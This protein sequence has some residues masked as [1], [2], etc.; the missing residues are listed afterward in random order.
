M[1]S[2]LSEKGVCVVS[3]G[4]SD[5]MLKKRP[6]CIPIVETEEHSRI[7]RL[8]YPDGFIDVHVIDCI[9]PAGTRIT[10]HCNFR[11]RVR[12]ED[13]WRR[14]CAAAG[15]AN[16]DLYGNWEF[17]PYDKGSSQRLIAVASG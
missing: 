10:K 13:D 3:Q 14:L 7:F 16:V 5:Q 6:Q 9:H 11:L 15:F 17:E 4:Q 1:R 8:E 12:L 2:V